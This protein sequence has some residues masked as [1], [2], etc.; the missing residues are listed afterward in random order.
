MTRGARSPLRHHH[1]N[2]ERT[3]HIKEFSYYFS[4]TGKEGGLFST[5]FVFMPGDGS[6]QSAMDA[7]VLKQSVGEDFHRLRELLDRMLINDKGV[8]GAREPTFTDS[9]GQSAGGYKYVGEIVKGM[10]PS[11]TRPRYQAGVEFAF[12]WHGRQSSASI[13]VK[14]ELSH[15]LNIKV[16]EEVLA[17]P[18][19]SIDGDAQRQIERLR[20]LLRSPQQDPEVNL[21]KLLAVRTPAQ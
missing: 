1:E 12:A 15:E 16:M 19:L 14:L 7:A 17:L 2:S 3:M 8:K 13:K 18:D 4:T 20:Q 6:E 10:M 9:P 21:T 5:D 11:L